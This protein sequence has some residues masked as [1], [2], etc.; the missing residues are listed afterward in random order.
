MKTPLTIGIKDS[1]PFIKWI[2]F[3]EQIDLDKQPYFCLFLCSQNKTNRIF[4]L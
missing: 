1:F 4:I 3:K 2:G